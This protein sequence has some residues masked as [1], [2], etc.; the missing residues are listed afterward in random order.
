MTIAFLPP[1]TSTSRAAEIWRTRSSDLS[2]GTLFSRSIKAWATWVSISSGEVVG[3][4]AVRRILEA[5]DILNEEP[6][7]EDDQHPILPVVHPTQ[8]GCF[9]T[10]IFAESSIFKGRRRAIGQ[11]TAKQR[12]TRAFSVR[13]RALI[14]LGQRGPLRPSEAYAKH[15]QRHFPFSATTT[16]PMSIKRPIPL[17]T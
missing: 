4:L 1:R 12:L 8:N 6:W 2:S 17:P 3:A 16:E 13:L 9:W 14:A 11:E 10:G 5:T 7:N 15:E